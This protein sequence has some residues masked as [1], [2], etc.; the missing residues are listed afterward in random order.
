MSYCKSFVLLA[1]FVIANAWGEVILVQNLD[2]EQDVSLGDTLR[3]GLKLEDSGE[4][5]GETFLNQFVGSRLGDILYVTKVDD[6]ILTVIVA[7]SASKSGQISPYTFKFVG[8]KTNVNGM[9][10]LDQIVIQDVEYEVGRS[11]FD[12]NSAMGI[13]AL[14]VALV[15]C[16]LFARKRILRKR[17]LAKVLREREEKIIQIKNAKLRNDY[18]EIYKIRREILEFSDC[19]ESILNDFM[20]KINQLQYLPEWNGNDYSEIKSLHKKLCDTLRVKNG[21]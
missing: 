4:R 19:D 1:L 16:V 20:D 10:T 2:A 12:L 18:E 21:V 6:D 17:Q 11:F 8:F 3:V 14:F 9:K 15:F 7:P 13:L 5:L